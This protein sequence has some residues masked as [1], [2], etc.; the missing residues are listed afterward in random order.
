MRL[1]RV[2]LPLRSVIPALLI[3][4]AGPLIWTKLWLVPPGFIGTD[5]YPQSIGVVAVALAAAVAVALTLAALGI[6]LRI[7][8]F[9][10]LAP[11]LALIG[12]TLGWQALLVIVAA[13][14]LIQMILTALRRPFISI[15][16]TLF[17]IALIHQVFWRAVSAAI[18][19]VGGISQ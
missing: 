2:R 10:N 9:R 17:A 15:G 13:T 7:D 1:D 8:S 19:T 18:T 11:P 16:W 5:Y 3:A 6:L 4:V 12:A 14:S